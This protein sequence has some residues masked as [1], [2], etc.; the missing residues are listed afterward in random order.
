MPGM[1]MPPAGAQPRSGA[2]PVDHTNMPGM[3][4]APLSAADRKLDELVARLLSDSVVR[5][6]IQTDSALKRRWD[7]AARR[8]LLLHNPR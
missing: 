8:T 6:R 3:T 2:A 1:N 5:S 4:A 7:E